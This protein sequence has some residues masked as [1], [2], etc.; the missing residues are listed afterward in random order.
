M[1][2]KPRRSSADPVQW[3]VQTGFT[4]DQAGLHVLDAT[5]QLQITHVTRSEG[6]Y[7]C[8]LET[9]TMPDLSIELEPDNK[10]YRKMMDD[11]ETPGIHCN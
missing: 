2:G 9:H 11:V 7:H 8:H 10:K 5:Q 6:L 3:W 4:W 1:H